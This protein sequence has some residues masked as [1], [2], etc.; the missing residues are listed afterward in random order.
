MSLRRGNTSQME[1]IKSRYDA[2]LC[3]AAAD[4]EAAERICSFLERAWVPGKRR[5]VLYL[6][7]S[8]RESGLTTET[9]T[10]LE[11]SSYLIV[12]CSEEACASNRVAAEIDYF[13]H[14]RSQN[15]SHDGSRLL[16]CQ[17]GEKPSDA[18]APEAL[19]LPAPLRWIAQESGTEPYLPDLRGY[20]PGMDR[21]DRA[22][23]RYEP[24]AL[25]APLVGL[26]DRAR[27]AARKAKLRAFALEAAGLMVAGA[28]G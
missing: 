3:F 28:V 27:V 17:L 23:I 15:D 2:V 4:T 9:K 22:R 10:A 18:A 26:R 21:R 16:A 6:D 24:L 19:A 13:A 25:L 20:E 7:R 8:R 1:R 5:R 11:R 12:C 14:L